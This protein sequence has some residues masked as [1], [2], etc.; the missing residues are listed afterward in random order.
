MLICV[1]H[2]PT[3]GSAGS[4]TA[5]D[6]D[7]E[8]SADVQGDVTDESVTDRRRSGRSNGGRSNRRRRRAH[9]DDDASLGS[10]SGDSNSQQGDSEDDSYASHNNSDIDESEVSF[11]DRRSCSIAHFL[12][13]I[14]CTY[15]LCMMTFYS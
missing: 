2:V 5:A 6:S 12:Q 9:D 14:C 10:N 7:A 8:I 1:C 15:T 13:D 4:G 11:H 3:Q